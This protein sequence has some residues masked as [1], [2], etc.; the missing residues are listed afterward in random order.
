MKQITVTFN[1]DP[2][3]ETVSGIK[4]FID[5]VEKKKTTTRTSK[6]KEIVLEDEAII[7]LESNKLVLNNKAAA[8]MEV[9]YQDRI[10]IKYEKIKGQKFPIPVI[11]TDI[12]FGAEGSGNK[13][14][15]T[16]TISYRGNANTILAEYGN[17]FRL[18]EFKPGIWKL[19]TN[20]ETN[21]DKYKAIL[22][23]IDENEEEVTIITQDEDNYEIEEMTFKL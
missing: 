12:S 7:T 6:P 15:K 3:T 17:E 21:M 1:F 20:Q 8:D 4:T 22:D 10:L 11:G 19:V 5:G 23:S 16:N 18:E 13:L 2:E 14:T 9:S